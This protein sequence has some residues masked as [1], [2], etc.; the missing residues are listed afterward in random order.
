M[1][2]EEQSFEERCA[3]AEQLLRYHSSLPVSFQRI[4]SAHR[5]N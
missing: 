1:V 5:Q 4:C 3:I 2:L